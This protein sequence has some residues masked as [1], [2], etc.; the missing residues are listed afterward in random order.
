VDVTYRSLLINDA[1]AIACIALI[2]NSPHQWAPHPFTETLFVTFLITTGIALADWGIYIQTSVVSLDS[3]SPP[4][5][6]HASGQRK[7]A[8]LLL[9]GEVISAIGQVH[10][11]KVGSKRGRPRQSREAVLRHL[12]VGF[13]RGGAA[14]RHG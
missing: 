12:G 2:H 9:L 8:V 6:S 3:L 4:V 5:Y 14:L 10:A 1:M 11:S 13:V 7:V